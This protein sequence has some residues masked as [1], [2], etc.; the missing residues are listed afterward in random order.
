RRQALQQRAARAEIARHG[1]SFEIARTPDRGTQASFLRT[2]RLGFA[3]VPTPR[4][5]TRRHCARSAEALEKIA[6]RDAACGRE[7]RQKLSHGG[8]SL[9]ARSEEHT[10][11]L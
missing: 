6:R 5:T 11:E 2:N 9:R 10:S 1:L 8:G 4:Q 3:L 7:G